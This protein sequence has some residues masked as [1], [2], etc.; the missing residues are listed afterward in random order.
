MVDFMSASKADAQ[1]RQSH[2]SESRSTVQNEKDRRSS[3]TSLHPSVVGA[4]VASPTG[5]TK[6]PVPVEDR[7]SAVVE[8]NIDDKK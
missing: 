1:S 3:M 7:M 2:S 4:S 8:F 5:N 6:Q